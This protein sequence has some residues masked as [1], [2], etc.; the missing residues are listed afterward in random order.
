[1]Y[2]YDIREYK[3]NLRDKYKTIRTSFSPDEKMNLDM[4]I[5]D[6]VSRLR[7]YKNAK[8]LMCY[9]STPIEVNTVPIIEMAMR[10]N[11]RVAVPRCVDNT[12]EMEFYY[13]TS[14]DDL[15]PRTFGVLEPIDGKCEKMTD[16]SDSICIVPGLAF[17]RLGFRLGYGKGY[18]DRFLC[19]YSGQK[20]GIVYEDCIRGKL[21]HGRYDIPV[22]VLV[23]ENAAKKILPKK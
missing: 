12:R 11:K 16:F 3:K 5:A 18:Y 4:S 14:M 1:M 23:S 10:D 22:D 7:Q 9:V 2:K 13:I 6:R 15:A 8:T 19:N 21:P 20:I 17:D